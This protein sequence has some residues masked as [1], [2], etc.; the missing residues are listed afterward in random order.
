MSVD[1][2][3]MSELSRF[4]YFEAFKLNDSSLFEFPLVR[5]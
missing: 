3:I 4:V 5:E 2:I 1:Y